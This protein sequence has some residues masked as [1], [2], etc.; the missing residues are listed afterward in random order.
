ML[1]PY[2]GKHLAEQTPLHHEKAEYGKCRKII[3]WRAWSGFMWGAL[4]QLNDQTLLLH[5]ITAIM[6]IL[7]VLCGV[8]Y[9]ETHINGIQKKESLYTVAL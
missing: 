2:V 4:A 3:L 7:E 1:L 8:L 5:T 6:Y 9:P